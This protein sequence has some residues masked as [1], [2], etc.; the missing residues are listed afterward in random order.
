MH[1]SKAEQPARLNA[2]EADPRQ[3]GRVTKRDW[4]FFKRYDDFRSV[5]EYALRR[6]GTAEAPWTVVEATDQRY[7]TLTVT[8]TLLEAL[9]QRLAA[10]KPAPAA[11]PLPES[12][13]AP[14]VNI[15]NWLNLSLAL[16]EKEYKRRLLKYQGKLGL[17]VRRLFAEK[18]SMILVFEGPDAAGKGGT[19]RRLNEA[20]DARVYQV[21]ATSAPTDEERAHPY[22]WR[23]WRQLPALG[24]VTIYDRSWY[25]R[26]LVERIEGFCAPA[27]W[28]RAYTEINA[29]EDQ[30]T[31]FGIILLKFWLAIS[32]DEQMRRFRDRETT[33]Y[34]Q[35][36]LTEEDWR[37]RAKWEAYETAACDMIEKTSSELAPWV[38]VEANSKEWA[39][40]RCSKRSSGVSKQPSGYEAATK[41]AAV[42][43]WTRGCRPGMQAGVAW[44]GSCRLASKTRRSAPRHS[45]GWVVLTASAGSSCFV[46]W[47]ALPTCLAA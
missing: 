13:P 4:K 17:L 43:A 23:F 31:E 38:L 46:P 11:A 16:D 35:Y 18:R 33:P 30:L 25:G 47:P 9:R 32:P 20:M 45:Q 5:S 29:F 19:I 40:S 41:T 3:R 36:K 12:P 10:G 39:A 37:N 2:L 44:I 42:N 14:P 8:H 6:T 7:Q 22:L 15:I 34:K 21:I 28:Q 27:E 24:R 1:L 26:V